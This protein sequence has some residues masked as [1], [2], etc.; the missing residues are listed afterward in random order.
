MIVPGRNDSYPCAEAQ[1]IDITDVPVVLQ[2]ALA[3]HQAGRLAQAGTL[4]RQILDVMPDHAGAL[5]LL[6]MIALQ[7]GKLD[8]AV[9]LIGRA[10][11]VNPL[12]PMCYLNLGNALKRQGRIDVAI[13]SYRKALELKPDYAEAHNNLG[14]IFK[15]QGRFDE[16]SGHYHKALAINPGIAEAH[17]SLGRVLHERGRLDEAVEHYF[18]ALSIRPDHVETHYNLG[19]AFQA[20]NKWE[21]AIKQYRQTIALNPRDYTAHNNLGNL[22]GAEMKAFDEAVACYRQALALKLDFAEAHCNLGN[23]LQRQGCLDEAIASYRQALTFK[24]DYVEAYSNLLLLCAYYFTSD[25]ASYLALARG[26]ELSCV[27]EQE[28]L[29]ANCRTFRRSPLAGRR[30]RVGYVSGDFRQHAVS[31]FI[32]RLFA[33]H[34]RSRVELFAYSINPRQDAVTGQLLVQVD[35]WV[36]VAGMSDDDARNRIDADEIDVLIDL[37]G[38]TAQN[39]MGIFAR[40]AAPVQAHY[41]GYFASTGL[42]EMDYFIGDEILTPPEMDSH[43]SERVWRLPRVWASY[44]A[45]KDAP[46]TNWRPA[47]DGTIWMGSFNNLGKL[48]SG[49]L[50]LWARV[51]HALPEGKLLLKTKALADETNRQRILEAMAGHGIAAGRIELQG[52]ITPGWA[53]HMAY[54]DRLDIALDPVGAIGGG[55]TTCD[56]L[57]MGVPTITLEGSRMAS[58]MTA[59]MLNAIDHAEWVAH[60]EAEYVGKAVALARDVELRKGLRLLQRER[61]A[62]SPLCDAKDLAM[63]LEHAYVEMFERWMMHA[64]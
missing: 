27:P 37:S 62:M 55:T 22:L 57:W 26:W 51:L 52:D 39:R 63:N 36:S 24:P 30:L 18:N 41:L 25:P 34:D 12:N 3:H 21:Q 5:H 8:S 47:Q 59:S 4:Y 29:A 33:K 1:A 53:E 11:Y 48:T 56:A 15:E 35:H 42:S 50:V 40:R 6:G 17:S 38:H 20:Q 44:D 32:E 54:Y 28:R 64:Q 13:E 46:A 58:R 7:G 14:N 49:T 2:A 61:M 23:I 10:I 43:F 60:S 45:R 16:A 31:Y 19:L 9:D